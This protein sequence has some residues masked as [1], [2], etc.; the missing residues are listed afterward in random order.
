MGLGFSSSRFLLSFGFLRSQREFE[1][2][3]FLPWRLPTPSILGTST[4]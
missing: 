3:I 2:T 1:V 4:E